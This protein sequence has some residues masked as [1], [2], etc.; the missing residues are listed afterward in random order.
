MKKRVLLSGW[1]MLL[2]LCVTTELP[3]FEPT[4]YECLAPAKVG[5][6]MDL[7]CRLAANALLAANLIDVPMTINFKP[8]GIG[9][10]AYNYVVGVHNNDPQLIVAASSGSAL[11][12]ATKNP[13]NK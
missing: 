5:G 11:N 3:A 13:A 8:G 7:S 6:G 2:L 1:L 9:A 4:A 10:V 12:I